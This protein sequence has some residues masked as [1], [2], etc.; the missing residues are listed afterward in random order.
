M[1]LVEE[2]ARQDR[3]IPLRALSASFPSDTDL[4][5]LSYAESLSIV[6]F[7]LERYGEEGLSALVD[8]FAEGETAEVGV[9]KALGISLEALEEEWRETLP[10]PDPDWV[11]PDATSGPSADD[12]VRI[13]PPAVVAVVAIISGTVVVVRRRRALREPEARESPP[14]GHDS[15]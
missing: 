12:W 5:L 1:L 6:E 4:A 15:P 10:A 3:L 14:S 13:V 2:A 11:A 9:H 7:I 8:T